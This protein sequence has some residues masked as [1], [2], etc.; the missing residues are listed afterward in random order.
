[1]SVE[2]RTAIETQ[3]MAELSRRNIDLVVLFALGEPA[4]VPCLLEITLSQNDKTSMRASWVLEKLSD[5]YP[6]IMDKY[7]VD[8][9]NAFPTVQSSSVRRTLAK[10]LMLHKIPES[11]EGEALNFCIKMIESAKEPVAVKANCMTI[12]FNLLPK[13]PELK[14]EVFAIIENQ[15]PFNSVGFKSRFHVLK[16][17][18]GT[19]NSQKY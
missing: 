15:I 9:V 12:L 7:I 8:I 13:Y 5:K 2:L 18:L 6:G 1:M 14:N 19:S 16:K 10:V 4:A 11:V 3:L 17:G